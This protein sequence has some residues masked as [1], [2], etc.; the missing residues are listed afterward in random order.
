[1]MIDCGSLRDFRENLLKIVADQ[2][3]DSDWAG[4][5]M[6][7]DALIL[8]HRDQDHY[9]KVGWIL[10]QPILAGKYPKLSVNKIY[11]SWS[12]GDAS[13]L[14][15]YN[16]ARL[17][18]VVCGGFFNT[19]ELYE[20]TINDEADA[21]NF[22]TTWVEADGFKAPVEDPS[23][24][25]TLFP[26][27]NRRLTLFSG[28]TGGGKEWSVSLI[29]GNVRKEN[30]PIA[31]LGND[32]NGV[33]F[34]DGATEDNARRLITLLQIGDK[35][36]LFCGDATFSTEH[37]L[38]KNQAA[39]ISGAQFVLV[40]H[41]GSEWASSIPFVNAVQARQVG[42]SAEYQEH[43][44]LHPR[45][46]ALKRWLDK[47]RAA[48]AHDLDYW[49]IDNM[50]AAAILQDWTNRG[51]PQWGTGDFKWLQTLPGT[52]VYYGVRT[53]RGLLYRASVTRDVSATA[54]TI[55]PDDPGAPGQ[56]LR[57]QIG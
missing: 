6:R 14:G 38:V 32:E 52:N 48:G 16:G 57:Y 1:V 29:A 11:F 56:F 43:A 35:K 3:R 28:T 22:Y 55:K 53:W 49:V 37:F 51:L 42:V 39:L 9:N 45:G 12:A 20:V 44:N 26:I 47:A 15:H 40:P 27:A 8:T 25:D 2:V 30:G 46:T 21:G 50:Q 13:P 10:G 7:I 19:S 4:N 33:P 34:K 41:H 36:A 31:D 24:G 54:F 5:K 23:S 18:E 17:N